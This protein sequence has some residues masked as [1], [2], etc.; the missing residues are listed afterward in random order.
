MCTSQLRRRRGASRLSTAAVV[1]L[2]LATT[3]P[4][5]AETTTT[6]PPLFEPRVVDARVEGVT[7]E[8]VE[9]SLQIAVTASRNVTI[10]TLT[11]SDGFLDKIPVHVSPLEGRWQ[12]Q[13]GEEFV[14]PPRVVVTAYARDALGI[15]S[16]GDLLAR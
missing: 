8:R 3:G 15:V 9:V 5:A 14:I 11:F 13:R 4:E 12:L 1:A 7:L 16:L 2:V 10:R 6:K